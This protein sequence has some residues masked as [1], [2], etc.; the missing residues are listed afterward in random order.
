[1]RTSAET[2]VGGAGVDRLPRIFFEVD[3]RQTNL[4]PRPV[5]QPA[6]DGAAACERRI[7]LRDLIIFGHVR[8][9]V[10]LAIELRKRRN[11]RAESEP[12]LN[13]R[14]HREA[15]GNGQRARIAETD[16]TDVRVRLAAEGVAATPE[17]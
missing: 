4:A 12:G 6:R 14:V 11:L 16:R 15:V 13:D 7:V 1:M 5:R 3:T 9:E 10:V 17:H 2:S 8:I